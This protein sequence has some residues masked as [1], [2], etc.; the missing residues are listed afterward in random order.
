MTG[1]ALIVFGFHILCY[2]IP[3]LSSL[4][5]ERGWDSSSF[6]IDGNL[7]YE[8]GHFRFEGGGGSGSGG[9]T[10]IKYSN[11]TKR[12]YLNLDAVLLLL[13]IFM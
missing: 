8:F 7:K 6:V 5:S 10:Q 1:S 13:C 3:C 4:V 9:D 2:K 11:H 12:E